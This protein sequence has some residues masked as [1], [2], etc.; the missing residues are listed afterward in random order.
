MGWV[1]RRIMRW[2]IVPSICG[3]VAVF[4]AFMS[5]LSW[6]LLEEWSLTI[7]VAAMSISLMLLLVD[8]EGDTPISDRV[9]LACTDRLFGPIFVGLSF[10]FLWDVCAKGFA[11]WKIC[12]TMYP[13]VISQITSL[14]SDALY[15]PIWGDKAWWAS[16]AFISYPE[17]AA[18]VLVVLYA[19][20]RVHMWRV[21][22]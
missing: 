11:F 8:V 18:G 15:M 4:I 21:Q 14:D 10:G 7:A 6:S 5:G 19:G 9:R 1:D 13:P 22:R 2:M 12:T 3:Q 17:Y 20:W 16:D